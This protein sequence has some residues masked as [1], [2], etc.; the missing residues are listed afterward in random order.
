MAPPVD[1][2]TA[3]G[4]DIQFGTNV[5]G[6]YLFT[7]SLLPVL[8]HT[9]QTRKHRVPHVYKIDHSFAWM[10]DGPVRVVNTSSVGHWFALKGGI[11]YATIVPNDARADELRNRLGKERLYAQSKWVSRLAR[12]PWVFKTQWRAFGRGILCLRTSLRAGTSLKGSSLPLCI[13]VSLTCSLVAYIKSQAHI[14]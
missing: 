6:H 2:K 14:V 8:I 12:P 11:D 4:Y 7:M 10:I 5:L 3:N 13:L 9:A 1:M